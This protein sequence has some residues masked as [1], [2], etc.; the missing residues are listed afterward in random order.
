LCSTLAARGWIGWTKAQKRRLSDAVYRCLVTDQSRAAP[1]DGH[2]QLR[3]SRAT[4]SDDDGPALLAMDQQAAEL[5][6]A[7]EAD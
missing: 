3:P 5:L 2:Q 7:F 6:L 4:P 1:S